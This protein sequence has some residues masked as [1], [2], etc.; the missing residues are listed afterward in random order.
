MISTDL[1]LNCSSADSY[2][3]ISDVDGYMV[4]Y[5]CYTRDKKFG[6]FAYIFDENGETTSDL[7]TVKEFDEFD[8]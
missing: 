3:L 8:S 1:S 6:I 2:I 7:I 5:K 4:A